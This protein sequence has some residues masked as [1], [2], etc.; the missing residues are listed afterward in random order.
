MPGVREVHV[1]FD[2][3]G[4]AHAPYDARRLA[5]RLGVEVALESPLPY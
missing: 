4:H 1:Y 5:Q 2:N 3:D